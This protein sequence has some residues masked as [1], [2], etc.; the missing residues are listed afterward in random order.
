MMEGL[1]GLRDAFSA[2]LLAFLVHIN[3]FRPTRVGFGFSQDTRG[4][5]TQPV[6]APWLRICPYIVHDRVC[7]SLIMVWHDD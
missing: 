6:Q 5:P 2:S 4:T 7:F 3:S 1:R